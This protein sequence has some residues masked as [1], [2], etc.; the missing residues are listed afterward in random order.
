[1]NGE[2]LL[3][4]FAAVAKA[5]EAIEGMTTRFSMA[6]M[7]TVLT[8]Q[9]QI[10]SGNILEIG[11]FHGRSAAILAAHLNPQIERLKLVDVADRFDRAS[12]ARISGNIDFHVSPSEKIDT[13][14]RDHELFRTIH[15]DA[16]HQFVATIGELD[17]AEAHLSG[18]GVII[19]DDFA[20]L[21]YSQN[22]AAIFKYLYTTKTNLTPF[23]VTNEKVYLCRREDFATYGNFILQNA[24]GEM[25][26]RGFAT[27]IAR[28]DAVEDYRAF[29]LRGPEPNEAP[30]FYGES[31]Y[32]PYYREA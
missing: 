22:I 6:V 7:D 23:L 3:A 18:H 8:F 9:R 12:L 28:T 13:V 4:R 24:M 2:V 14:I 10:A 25:S 27:C 11:V 32:G 19:C 5:A 15:I 20:N 1:M 30:G 17:F 26:L 31:I 16:S 21:N 29:Y